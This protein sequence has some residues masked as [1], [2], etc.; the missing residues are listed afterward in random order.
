MEEEEKEKFQEKYNNILAAIPITTEAKL[1]YFADVMLHLLPD[2][3]HTNDWVTKFD[4]WLDFCQFYISE[5]DSAYSDYMQVNK[6]YEKPYQ[7]KFRPMA[8]EKAEEE[9]EE[10]LRKITE[11]CP[12]KEEDKTEM[13]YQAARLFELEEILSH[14][15]Y[16][17]IIEE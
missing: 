1:Q 10:C 4:T 14:L 6:K 13:L 5:F 2:I 3:F 17:K 16:Q 7:Y 15:F 11:I 9:T 8:I 12:T